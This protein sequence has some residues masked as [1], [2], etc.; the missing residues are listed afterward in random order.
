[1]KKLLSFQSS[2]RFL[3]I[4]AASLIFCGCAH[5][6]PAI[7]L[8][9][10]ILVNERIQYASRQDDWEATV[11]MARA[12]SDSASQACVEIARLEALWL[13]AQLDRLADALR[14]RF[15]SMAWRLLWEDYPRASERI[16]LP[17]SKEVD[18]AI[19]QREQA[20][21]AAVNLPNDA[22][23]AA[24]AEAAAAQMAE[25]RN[26][27]L[28][29]EFSGA[30]ALAARVEVVRESIDGR[31]TREMEYLRAQVAAW[32]SQPCPEAPNF[33][34]SWFESRRNDYAALHSVQVEGL[35]ALRSYLDRPGTLELLVS[36]A[37]DSLSENLPFFVVDES[38]SSDFDSGF[39]SLQRQIQ[40]AHESL[41]EMIDSSLEALRMDMGSG[42]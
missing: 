30:Y 1:M 36:G 11:R 38:S 15:E 14:L 22:L 25:L 31:V 33:E 9:D 10:Q 7:E 27:K 6:E 16:L 23:L 32:A 2:Y 3:V 17:L 4:V 35:V 26:E 24:R 28:R 12:A 13:D 5:R 8:A 41:S 37:S 34:A 18:R 20:A 40:S 19:Q 21:R 29:L 42:S 39:E